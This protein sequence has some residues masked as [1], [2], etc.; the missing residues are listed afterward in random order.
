MMSNTQMKH[1]VT[2]SQTHA[3]DSLL[4]H[5][6]NQHC[7]DDFGHRLVACL[8]TVRG[9]KHTQDGVGRLDD[10]NRNLG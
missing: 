4:S 7:D 2:L 6:A 9:P 8:D 1:W 3:R 10:D 5:D